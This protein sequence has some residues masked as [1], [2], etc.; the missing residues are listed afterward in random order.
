MAGA[1]DDYVI[2]EDEN[3]KRITVPRASLPA[4]AAASPSP[5]SA[6]P[7]AEKP[8]APAAPAAKPPAKSPD[9]G[10]T[11]PGILAEMSKTL[12]GAA[13]YGLALAA[14]PLIPEVA[15]AGAL[16]YGVNRAL[17]AG[18]PAAITTAAR[19][20]LQMRDTGKVDPDE[21]LKGFLSDAGWNAGLGAAFEGAGQGLRRVAQ[22]ARAIIPS[23]GT[24][25]GASVGGTPGA[26]AG[27]A[28]GHAIGTVLDQIMG[29]A[30]AE[31]KV[32][33]PRVQPVTMP[34]PPTPPVRAAAPMPA[35]IPFESEGLV[36]NGKVAPSQEAADE[37]RALQ[38]SFT[39]GS[40]EWKAARKTR[41]MIERDLEAQQNA[42]PK[43]DQRYATLQQSGANLRT[44][45]ETAAEQ[46][47]AKAAREDAAYQLA[48]QKYKFQTT[49]AEQEQLKREADAIADMQR[50]QAAIDRAKSTASRTRFNRG[51]QASNAWSGLSQG[52]QGYE[53]ANEPK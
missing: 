27:G 45:A 12:K 21:V 47:A 20:G 28:G 23:L 41:K 31:A 14:T 39:K 15:G 18:V 35:R 26:I 2:L 13:P 43:A 29:S 33:P 7:Q 24:A 42:I 49:A 50:Q 16:A 10:L 46:A 3:G 40:D 30:P 8:S 36:I 38:D 34:T 5:A 51:V 32:I 11:N 22:G 48:Q 4:P 52:V 44:P 37:A 6:G 9:I 25:V 19:T 53:Q 1:G 17:Q